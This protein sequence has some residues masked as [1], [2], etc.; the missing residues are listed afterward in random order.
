[1]TRIKHDIIYVQSPLEKRKTHNERWKYWFSP[2]RLE[3]L[4][5]S[6]N[7]N[8]ESSIG[9][10]AF[11]QSRGRGKY[12]S[13]ALLM[14]ELDLLCVAIASLLGS[15]PVP[16]KASGELC[17]IDHSTRPL[18]K[19]VKFNFR[20]AL[21]KRQNYFQA[22]TKSKAKATWNGRVGGVGRRSTQCH[23]KYFSPQKLTVDAKWRKNR[24]WMVMRDKWKTL[25]TNRRGCLTSGRFMPFILL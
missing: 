24:W 25:L 2:I 1:M 11:V 3:R 15:E 23:K 9:R 16:D 22:K 7:S 5:A 8:P 13:P 18:Q 17:K 20:K 10:F 6:E 12:F 19:F 21:V 14:K 4:T